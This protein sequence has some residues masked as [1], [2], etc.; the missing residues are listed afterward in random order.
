MGDRAWS[1]EQVPLREINA[2]AEEHLCGL[3]VF[4]S[5]GDRS[6]AEV[7]GQADDRLYDGHVAIAAC[8]VAHEVDV[9]LQ[10]LDW[11]LLE[12]SETGESGPEV[13]QR[14]LATKLEHMLGEQPGFID[15]LHHGGFSDLENDVPRIGSVIG[16]LVLDEAPDLGAPRGGSR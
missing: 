13:V 6:L 9:N 7:P 15:V 12:I 16:Q 5:F 8:E 1:S 2:Q 3:L 14:K 10:V 11:N 4:N